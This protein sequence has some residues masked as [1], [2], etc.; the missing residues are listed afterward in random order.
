[1]MVFLIGTLF[2]FPH[3]F[4]LTFASSRSNSSE[5]NVPRVIKKEKLIEGES[6]VITKKSS[7]HDKAIVFC[8]HY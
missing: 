5:Q 2:F 3:Y 4:R 7:V 8:N 6:C 1:M